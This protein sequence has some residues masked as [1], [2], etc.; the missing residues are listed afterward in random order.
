MRE[1]AINRQASALSLLTP[2]PRQY[3]VP[4]AF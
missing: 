3:Y 4:L 2:A 1:C